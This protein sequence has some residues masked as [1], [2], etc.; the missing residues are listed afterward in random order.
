MSVEAGFVKKTG[1]DQ[2]DGNLSLLTF[3]GPIQ[4]RPCKS[5]RENKPDMIVFSNGIEIGSARNRVGRVSGNE[6]VSMAL[7]HPQITGQQDVLF[8]NL[9]VASGQDDEDVFAV[10]LN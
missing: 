2:Y 9:G 10:I 5:D 4:L 7:K 1:D 6:H 8:A 3:Q